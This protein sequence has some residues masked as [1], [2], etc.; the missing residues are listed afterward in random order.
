MRALRAHL[1]PNEEL[2]FIGARRFW[3]FAAVA[4]LLTCGFV[5]DERLVSCVWATTFDPSADP[6]VLRCT[7]ANGREFIL[8]P[9]RRK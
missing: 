1:G 3:G 6:S 7:D 2:D 9:F 8:V 4:I 5:S